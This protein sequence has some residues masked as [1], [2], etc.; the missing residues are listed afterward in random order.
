MSKRLIIDGGAPGKRFD[1]AGGFKETIN[2]FH[3]SVSIL[4]DFRIAVPSFFFLIL[5]LGI[6]ISYLSSLDPPSSSFW[7]L[8]IG[9]L[10]SS[11]LG[12]FPDHIVLMQPILDRVDIFV[13]IFINIIFQ[14]ATT[15]LIY[16]GITGRS[17]SFAGA[18]RAAFGKYLQLFLI[19]LFASL[20]IFLVF[21]L[22]GNFRASLS[23][24]AGN[25]VYA[26]SMAVAL[27]IQGL[28]LYTT[29]AILLYDSNL[30][31]SFRVSISIAWN[32]PATTF[33]I[34]FIPFI[35]TVPTTF[36]SI[37]SALIATRLSPDFIIHNYIVS[38]VI[39]MIS[40]YLITAGGTVI[41]LQRMKNR[42]N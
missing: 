3:T 42:L 31:R 4:K 20:F 24:I 17:L 22:A 25:T 2:T 1:Y 28:F 10:S 15:V 34:V 19:S 27:A 38:S 9:G 11:D 35:L 6:L 29:P 26:V 32:C 33:F 21:F 14:G 16:S 23:P 30:F 40:I 36:I 8:F 5:H 18:F 41:F 39:E 7:A 37:K 12:H 13:E